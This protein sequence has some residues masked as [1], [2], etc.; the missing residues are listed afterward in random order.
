MHGEVAAGR[1]NNRPGHCPERRTI[2]CISRRRAAVAMLLAVT[3]VLASS[4]GEARR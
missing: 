4:T 1:R 3:V 2:K